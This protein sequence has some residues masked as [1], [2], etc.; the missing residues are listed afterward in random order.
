MLSACGAQRP[1]GT[2]AYLNDVP[3]ER[4]AAHQS[5]PTHTGGEASVE[6][7]TRLGRKTINVDEV[8][9]GNICYDTGGG[10][11]YVTCGIEIPPGSRTLSSCK[12]AP[13]QLS[14]IAQFISK[15]SV[16]KLTWKV[17]LITK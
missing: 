7:R 11:V 10:T 14:P 15:R 3:E 17:V 6:V 5:H 12:T 4:T 2:I 9:R 1:E 16:T 8:I 13:L